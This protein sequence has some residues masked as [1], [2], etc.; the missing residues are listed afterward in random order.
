[1]TRDRHGAAGGCSAR[2]R[3][4]RALVPLAIAI[5]ALPLSAC[6]ISYVDDAG[7]QHILGLASIII[8]PSTE[9]QPTAGNVVDLTTIGLSVN[10]MPDGNSLSLGYSRVVTASLKNNVL[11]LGNPLAIREQRHAR[12]SKVVAAIPHYDGGCDVCALP[13]DG[14]GADGLRR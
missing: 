3:G 4:R 5:S 1:M 10:S 9:G 13:V 7:N 2:R 11:V 8:A 6:A 14:A 12:T